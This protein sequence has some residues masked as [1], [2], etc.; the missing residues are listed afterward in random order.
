M[1]IQGRLS[2][3]G[4]LM[5]VLVPSQVWPALGAQGPGEFAV[6]GYLPDYRLDGV[7]PR[8]AIGVTDI[9]YFSIEAKADGSLDARRL[10]DKALRLLKRF[11]KENGARVHVA[12][13]GWE[14]SAGFARLSQDPRAR[15]RFVAELT[16]LCAKNHLDGVDLDWEHPHNDAEN[17]GYAALLSELKTAFAP[18][19]LLLSAALADWQ[20]PGSRAYDALDRIHV[21]AYDHDGPRHATF[22][23]A[24]ADAMTFVKRGV[25]RRKICLGL[26]FYGRLST[27]SKVEASYA[28]ILAQHHPKASLDQAGGFYFNGPD[29]IARK[30]RF[31]RDQGLGGVMIWELGQDAPGA[32]SLLGVI[33]RANH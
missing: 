32:E 22:D 3:L 5:L 28:E 21:M 4:F 18:R 20:D 6:V 9:V 15:A 26:P 17:G 23:Q 19:K 7:D 31:A 13:G 10:S 25:P 1:L 12:V 14:R 2:T 33:R 29:T 11:Q 27:D 30:T 24:K 16:R 8:R